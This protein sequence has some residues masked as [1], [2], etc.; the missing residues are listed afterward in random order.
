MKK[1]NSFLLV[2]LAA[3]LVTPSCSKK[4]SQANPCRIINIQDIQPSISTTYNITYNDQKQIATIQSI[5]GS[6]TVNKVF[7]YS[8]HTEMIVTTS[9]TSSTTDSIT[10]NDDGLILTDLY[11]DGAGRNLTAYTYSG[12]Q[13]LKS[14]AQD[15]SGDPAVTTLYTFANGDMTGFT[16]GSSTANFTYDA[17]KP[18]GTGDYW[19]IVQ[20]LSYGAPYVKSSHLV[21]GYSGGGTVASFNYTFDNTGKIASLVSRSGGAIENISYQ[22]DCN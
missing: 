2:L 7:T 8:G 18:S 12:N 16:N 21:T 15:N 17:S 20:L 10:L 19:Q 3:L 14:V 6:V 22:Y 5:T 1:I 9:G 11:I 13:V 4:S